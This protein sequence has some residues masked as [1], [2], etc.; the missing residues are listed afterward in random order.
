[1]TQGE[2]LKKNLGLSKFKY[3][4][5]ARAIISSYKILFVWYDSRRKDTPLTTS[6]IR[7]WPWTSMIFS[8]TDIFH[9]TDKGTI[10]APP[11]DIEDYNG[12]LRGSLIITV[13]M[14]GNNL[15]NPK[16]FAKKFKADF[17][18]NVYFKGI[19]LIEEK[20]LKEYITI[21]DLMKSQGMSNFTKKFRQ[22]RNKAQGTENKLSVLIDVDINKEK[23]YIIFY[24]FTDATT[25]VYPDDYKFKDVD[26]EANFKLV[27]DPSK[28]YTLQIKILNFFEWLDTYPD[29]KIIT[30]KDIKDIFS[31]SYVQLFSDDP[32][33]HW[34]GMNFWIS[35]LDGSIYPT[36]IAPKFWNRSDLHG[37][38]NAFVSKHL[39]G[40][41][42]NIKF[43]YNPMASM[44]TGKLIKKGLLYRDKSKKKKI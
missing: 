28:T 7:S 16:V 32:S 30:M 20:I 31:I 11:I 36:D 23:D 8:G 6:R 33:F 14:V 35:Q 19:N 12:E 26:P 39:G 24:W 3:V 10:F 44:L 41:I 5:V 40:L 34:Q 43:W 17:K 9:G 21:S 13:D 22:Q 29:K 25:N 2:I 38:G 15:I 27:L 1:M 42:N 18:I 37:D 4:K